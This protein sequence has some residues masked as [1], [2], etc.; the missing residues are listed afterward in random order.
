MSTHKPSAHASAP[1]AI[2]A[3]SATP[4]TASPKRK[5]LI[6]RSVKKVLDLRYGSATLVEAGVVLDQLTAPMF[7]DL[8]LGSESHKA[9][10]KIQFRC[11][12]CNAPVRIHA[13]KNSG[14]GKDAFFSHYGQKGVP[15]AWRSGKEI[16][17]SSAAQFSGRHEGFE[18]K[19]LKTALVQCLRSDPGFTNISEER[20]L[21]FDGERRKPDVS[22]SYGGQFIAFEIQLAR[23]MLKTI[24]ERAAAYAKA[25]IRLV[26]ITT[27]HVICN[28]PSQAFR[29]LYFASGGRIFTIDQGSCERSEDT[30]TLHLR[31]LTIVPV[32]KPPFSVFNRW[33]SRM[34]GPQ[35]ILMPEAQRHSEGKR[36]YGEVLG[37]QVASHAPN[38]IPL[39]K[40]AIGGG[41]ELRS[42]AGAWDKLRR[43]VGGRDLDQAHA[44]GL[45][46]MLGWL[47]MVETLYRSKD[48][49]PGRRVDEIATGALAI[50]RSP[51]G[52]NWIPLLELVADQVPLVAQA[53]QPQARALMA[54]LKSQDNRLYS[55][56]LY[57]KHMLSVLH[58]WLAFHLLAK[59]PQSTPPEQRFS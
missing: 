22:A 30:K 45:R 53:L 26:W 37:Q 49:P 11:G 40:D 51:K 47:H 52:R 2:P 7:S 38:L 39:I 6:Q 20:V 16:N 56:H 44:D 36:R 35:V 42:V 15:C 17:S 29:D 33:S 18:H 8:R 32:V 27:A 46:S 5:K 4:K 50:L 57:H 41:R 23:P 34:V 1:L 25:G 43:L 14:E 3:I 10:G 9:Q 54:R 12:Q 59:A 28:L 48:L 19:E 21:Q 24:N 13:G 31:E 55:F 58:P